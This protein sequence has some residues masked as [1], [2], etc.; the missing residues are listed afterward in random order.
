MPSEVSTPGDTQTYSRMIIVGTGDTQFVQSSELD[1]QPYDED[2]QV[3]GEDTLTSGQ[4][5][6]PSGLDVQQQEI[7]QEQLNDFENREIYCVHST[8]R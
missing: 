2:I 1:T 8:F 7:K 3:C 4:D 5:K 6:Q